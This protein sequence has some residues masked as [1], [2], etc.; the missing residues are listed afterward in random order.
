MN[1]SKKITIN[2]KEY[3]LVYNA[4]TY[5][6]YGDVFKNQ[7]IFKDIDTINTWVTTQVTLETEIKKQFPDITEDE[8]IKNL[9]YSMIKNNMYEYTLA[10]MRIAYIGIYTAHDRKYKTFDEWLKE[11]EN[12]STNDLWIAEVTELAVSSFCR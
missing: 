4:L 3:E 7:D 5:I 8:L 12:F 1:N 10:V 2:N 9:S 11:I 6:A